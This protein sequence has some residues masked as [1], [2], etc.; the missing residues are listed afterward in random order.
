VKTDSLVVDSRGIAETPGS[1]LESGLVSAGRSLAARHVGR[2]DEDAD[3]SCIAKNDVACGAMNPAM[4][5]ILP[6]VRMHDD[7]L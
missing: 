4:L 1:A 5:G 3:G 2:R 7:P 6:A